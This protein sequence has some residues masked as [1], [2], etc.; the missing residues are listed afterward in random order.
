[1]AEEGS[2]EPRAG[3]ISMTPTEDSSVRMSV[4]EGS[5]TEEMYSSHHEFAVDDEIHNVSQQNS[6]ESAVEDARE[7]QIPTFISIN[8]KLDEPSNCDAGEHDEFQSINLDSPR[9]MSEVHKIEVDDL[10][11]EMELNEL[12][13]SSSKEGSLNVCNEV[14][15]SMHGDEEESPVTNHLDGVLVPFD[16]RQSECLSK[17][18]SRESHEDYLFT[19]D[20]GPSDEFF[21]QVDYSADAE[22]EDEKTQRASSHCSMDM[23][24]GAIRIMSAYIGFKKSDSKEANWQSARPFFDETSSSSS[25]SAMLVAEV[26]FGSMEF[27]LSPDTCVEEGPENNDELHFGTGGFDWHDGD[28]NWLS[29]ISESSDGASENGTDMSI[30]SEWSKSVGSNDSDGSNSD[31]SSVHSAKPETVS[32]QCP[33]LRVTATTKDAIPEEMPQLNNE[34]SQFHQQSDPEGEIQPEF[35]FCDSVD[36]KYFNDLYN[37]MVGVSTPAETEDKADTTAIVALQ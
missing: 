14:T 22:D 3:S 19:L 15:G 17:V 7:K 2:H 23:R 30:E 12:A 31:D 35:F 28:L 4:C 11:I 37:S 8:E 36:F 29:S 26:D 5:I 9:E 21:S 16:A 27:T 13:L 10:A 20:I 34:L 24:D 6:D 33:E 1:M 25:A 32:F 18:F